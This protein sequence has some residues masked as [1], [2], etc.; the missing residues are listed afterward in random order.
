MGQD[1]PIIIICAPN[2]KRTH[3][4]RPENGDSSYEIS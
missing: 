2:G 1:E 4:T 3:A